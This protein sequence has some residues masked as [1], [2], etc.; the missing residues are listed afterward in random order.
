MLN[1]L[2][3]IDNSIIDGYDK[4]LEIGFILNSY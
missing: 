2:L 1:E 3:L 4:W